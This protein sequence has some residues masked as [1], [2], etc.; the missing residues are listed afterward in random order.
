[1][2]RISLHVHTSYSY[3]CES[4]LKKIV[5]YCLKKN[6]THILISDHDTIEGALNLKYFN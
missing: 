4:D 6:I 1:M 3:D 5:K 2:N